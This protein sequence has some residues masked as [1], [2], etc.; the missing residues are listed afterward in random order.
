MNGYGKI[1]GWRPLRYRLWTVEELE[2]RDLLAADVIISEIMYS[3]R[4]GDPRDEW[5]EVHNS[6]TSSADLEGYQLADGVDFTFSDVTIPPG[7]YLVV[8]A[9]L[10]AFQ[11][12]Y[13][14]VVN[15]VGGWSGRLSNR[16]EA[17]ELVDSLGE[18]VDRV[19]YADSGDWAERRR[20]S[21]PTD[22]EG[23]V[24]EADHDGHVLRLRLSIRLSTTHWPTIGCLA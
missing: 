2:R 4:S 20:N 6:G 18:P 15:F 17:I 3:P 16:G 24:W 7:G 19:T 21:D 10:E 11:G 12:K 8:A 23:W 13:P 9:D 5:I 22:Q 1:L 14:A